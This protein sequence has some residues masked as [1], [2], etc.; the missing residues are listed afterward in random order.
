ME[1]PVYDFAVRYAQNGGARLHM[2]GHKGRGILG[3]EALDITEIKGADSLYEADGI[4]A[5]SERNAAEL[6][7]VHRTF[8]SAG[9]SSQ[10]LKAMLFLALQGGKSRTVLAARNVHKSFIQAAALLDFE[11]EWIWPQPYQLLSCAVSPQMLAEAL[12]KLAQPP[13]AVYLTSPDYLGHLQPVKA[14]AEICHKYNT[15]L[16]VDNAHGAYLHFLP[17][18]VH[19]ADL[20]AD[21]CCDSAHKTLPVLTGGAY[22]HLISDR[23]ANWEQNARQALSLFGSTSPSY[24]I[25]ES[26]DLCN[27]SLARDFRPQL[28]EAAVRVAKLKTGLKADGWTVED[29]EPLKLVIKAPG[30]ICTGTALA[31]RLRAGRVECE[32]A[33]PDYLVLMFSPKNDPA[34]YALVAQT[35]GCAPPQGDAS[36]HCAMRPPQKAMGIRSALFAPCEEIPVE[37]AL[38]RICGAPSVSC[39]PAVPVVVSGE[40]ITR[41]AIAVFRHYGIHSVVAVKE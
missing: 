21:A 7:G 38:G 22:L 1:T 41:E 23:A 2:P 39:P 12:E 6:F 26:L 17:E 30:D 33:D 8:F 31:D 32:Y 15:V 40:V 37:L 20:G 28:A 9:G 19:P 27:A 34:D 35:L 14:L 3:C 29:T 24:L 13:A 5:K 25:L 36:A 18:P 4:I 16:L 10:C 11:V